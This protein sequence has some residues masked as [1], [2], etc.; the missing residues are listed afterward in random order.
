MTKSP[1]QRT[2]SKAGSNS[3]LLWPTLL[4]TMT[5][6]PK[7]F[8]QDPDN[9]VRQGI[10]ATTNQDQRRNR[11]DRTCDDRNKLSTG[12]KRRLNNSV[13]VKSNMWPDQLHF[14]VLLALLNSQKLPQWVV[15]NAKIN[16]RKYQRRIITSDHSSRFFSF[17]IEQNLS[18]QNIFD[19][20]LEDTP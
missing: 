16:P 7:P 1:A 20:N 19:P 9:F 15:L 18:D 14:L 13:L 12:D 4:L 6:C 3:Q 5:R 17:L 2:D 8:L 10:P 11:P